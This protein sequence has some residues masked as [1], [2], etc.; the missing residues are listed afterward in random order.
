MSYI[1]NMAISVVTYTAL[2][3]IF[4]PAGLGV[5]EPW[6]A[7]LVGGLTATKLEEAAVLEEKQEHISEVEY[8][9]SATK[10]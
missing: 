3:L 5:S 7:D 1:V 9:P 6:E 4:P 8:L 10:V 2:S